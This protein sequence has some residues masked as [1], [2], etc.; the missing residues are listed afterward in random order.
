MNHFKKWLIKVL[1]GKDPF[2]KYQIKPKVVGNKL[3]VDAD[4]IRKS[5][6][7]MRQI[8]LARETSKRGF[9]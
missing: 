3:V 5:P 7:A 9:D 1:V 2:A 8:R 6:V 4:A